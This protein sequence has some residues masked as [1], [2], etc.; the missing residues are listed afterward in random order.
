MANKELEKWALPILKKYQS[1]LLLDD[2]RLT[3]EFTKDIEASTMMHH[4]FQYP[5]KETCIQY[6][7]SAIESWKKKEKEDLKAILI[8]ELCHSITDPLYDK[9]CARY[10]DKNSLNDERE[11]LT[12]HLA[13]IIVKAGL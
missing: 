7:N 4:L 9:A 11:R 2:H 1:I 8:H 10:V 13:N 5:Y 6:G 3:F 12:D